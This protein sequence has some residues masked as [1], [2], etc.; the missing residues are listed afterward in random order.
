MLAKWY[1]ELATTNEVGK[2]ASNLLDFNYWSPAIK[3]EC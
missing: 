2:T 3:I 1:L